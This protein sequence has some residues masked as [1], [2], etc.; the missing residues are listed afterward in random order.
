MYFTAI[1]T[2]WSVK[3]IY[4]T[5]NKPDNVDSE[6]EVVFKHIWIMTLAVRGLPDYSWNL[7]LTYISLHVFDIPAL[8]LQ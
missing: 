3:C 7:L 6:S 1:M 4:A 2:H 5:A 8:N